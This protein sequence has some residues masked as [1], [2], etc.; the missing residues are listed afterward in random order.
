MIKKFLIYFLGYF[1]SYLDLDS[2]YYRQ[3]VVEDVTRFYGLDEAASLISV[4]YERSI[5]DFRRN[6]RIGFSW[7]MMTNE[8]E[9][10]SYFDVSNRGIQF[11]NRKG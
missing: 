11:T 8:D 5:A 6:D 4:N 10:G 9:L 3:L 1:K 2:L 7:T